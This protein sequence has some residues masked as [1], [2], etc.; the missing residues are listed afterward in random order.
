VCPAL[1][2]RLH[3]GTVAL[4][5][6]LL[7]HQPDHERVT[8]I[9][10]CPAQLVEVMTDGVWHRDELEGW[11]SEDDCWRGYVRWSVG[12]ACDTS[13]G[14]TR[15]GNGLPSPTDP[16]ASR[17]PARSADRLPPEGFSVS[18]SRPSPS[19]EQRPVEVY[20]GSSVDDL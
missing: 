17:R 11:R 12:V 4:L 9:D 3:V 6:P 1:T 15:T 5:Q 13:A 14:S 8:M 10:V 19:S 2:A 7:G 20:P 18:V 16:A